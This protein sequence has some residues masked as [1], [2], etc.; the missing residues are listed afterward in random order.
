MARRV[1][2]SLF[3]LTAVVVVVQAGSEF[4]SAIG[5]SGARP[6]LDFG[7]TVL[8][9]GVAIAFAIFVARR[10]P[11]RRRVWSPLAFAACA[12]AMLSVVL[13][14][15]PPATTGTA[16]VVAGEALALA[17]GVWALAST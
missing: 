11:A 10:G 3:A 6:W 16:V 9:A 2:V 1:L 8:K 17:A 4:V 12:G 7:Y 14:G 15:K 5:G 13:L